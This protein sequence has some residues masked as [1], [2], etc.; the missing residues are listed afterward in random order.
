MSTQN[1]NSSA[2]QRSVVVN[3]STNALLDPAAPR[4]NC[5]RKDK[6]PSPTSRKH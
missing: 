5:E 3:G 2:P 6:A 1:T 4:P